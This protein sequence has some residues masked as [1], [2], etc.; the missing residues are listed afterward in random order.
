MAPVRTEQGALYSLSSFPEQ[1]SILPQK[2]SRFACIRISLRQFRSIA[3]QNTLEQSPVPITLFRQ[4][5]GL[6]IGQLPDGCGE[7]LPGSFKVNSLP[8]NPV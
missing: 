2:G 3:D 8:L 5:T 4:D 1:F 6:R 7:G